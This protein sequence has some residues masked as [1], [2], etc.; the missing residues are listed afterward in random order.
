MWRGRRWPMQRT[1]VPSWIFVIVSQP[2]YGGCYWSLT[3]Y[4][5]GYELVA[6]KNLWHV[7]E[8][9]LVLAK[10]SPVPLALL[11]EKT[12]GAP[13][14]QLDDGRSIY[15]SLAHCHN[16]PEESFGKT[17][18]WENFDQDQFWGDTVGCKSNMRVCQLRVALWHRVAGW[19]R[20]ALPGKLHCAPCTVNCELST[21]QIAMWTVNCAM[22]TVH[23]AGQQGRSWYRNDSLLEFCIYHKIVC[24]GTLYIIH[25]I[26]I[27]SVVLHGLVL[28]WN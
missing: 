26:V 23:C 15:A 3:C 12:R 22:C 21:V 24:F 4:G 5:Y 10:P 17:C 20:D 2:G 7:T 6:R 16:M 28:Q 13:D 1:G 18:I 8:E 9:T 14:A 25:G 27:D 11:V 19:H